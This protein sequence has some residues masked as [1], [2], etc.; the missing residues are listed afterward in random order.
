MGVETRSDSAVDGKAKKR[1]DADAVA[2]DYERR[3]LRARWKT[4]RQALPK[5]LVLSKQLAK[6][7]RSCAGLELDVQFEG[8][9]ASLAELMRSLSE[10]IPEGAR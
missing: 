8:T 4:P 1:R 2:T 10:K 3:A 6:I 7:H 9:A 5:L